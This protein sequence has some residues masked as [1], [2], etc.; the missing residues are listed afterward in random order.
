MEYWLSGAA[1][2]PIGVEDIVAATYI[3]GTEA[4]ERAG[5]RQDPRAGI[6]VCRAVGWLMGGS[7]SVRI[8]ASAS[9]VVI[10]GWL[11]L[12][13]AHLRREAGRVMATA[14]ATAVAAAKAL[15]LVA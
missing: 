1:A 4:W 11:W 8:I 5:P 6:G 9:R 12:R 10:A 14:T 13:V 15:V 3:G 7:V 2:A